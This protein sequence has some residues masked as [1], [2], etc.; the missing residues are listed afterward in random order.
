MRDKFFSENT[1]KKWMSHH[2]TAFSTALKV[3]V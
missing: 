3:Y 1:K 2:D